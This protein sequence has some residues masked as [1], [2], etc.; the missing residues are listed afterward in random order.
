MKSQQTET[1]GSTARPEITLKQMLIGTTFILM[2]INETEKAFKGAKWRLAVQR[3]LKYAWLWFVSS[4]VIYILLSYLDAF[5]N[6][7]NEKSVYFFKSTGSLWNL[8]S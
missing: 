1:C 4:K 5:E 3:T 7:F 8:N 6:S 2:Y